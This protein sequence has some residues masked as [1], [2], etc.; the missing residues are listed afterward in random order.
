[1]ACKVNKSSLVAIAPAGQALIVGSSVQFD[2]VRVHTGSA[3]GFT[4][5]SST[6]YLKSAGL[7]LV[8]FDGD[9]TITTTGAVT[10]QLFDG[11]VAVAGAEDTVQ[12]TQ[13]VPAG[14]HFSTILEVKPSCCAVDNT[15]VLQVQTSAVGN[16]INADIN[17][18]KLA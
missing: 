1:M 11:G 2:A 16:L 6:V 3:I 17:I 18:V 10:F 9:F 14:V 12:A 8:T 4:T 5:G 13:A 15:A 7:Y